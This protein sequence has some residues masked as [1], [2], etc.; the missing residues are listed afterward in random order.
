M[1]DFIIIHKEQSI[2]NSKKIR[3][4][5]FERENNIKINKILICHLQ[6]GVKYVT[7]KKM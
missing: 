7:I 5:S 4:V 6:S 2:K 1:T 3:K